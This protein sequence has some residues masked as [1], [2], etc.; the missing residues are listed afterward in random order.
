MAFKPDGRRDVVSGRTFAGPAGQPDAFLHVRSFIIFAFGEARD[1]RVGGF[2]ERFE[3]GG[4]SA[5]GVRFKDIR[6]TDVAPPPAAN[7]ADDLNGVE[8]VAAEVREVI[9]D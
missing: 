2:R 9:I 7:P 5:D 6:E 3:P 1:Q 4:E 8:T